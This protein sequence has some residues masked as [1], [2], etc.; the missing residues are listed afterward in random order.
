MSEK[1]NQGEIAT[2][3][4]DNIPIEAVAIV[5]SGDPARTIEQVRQ[6]LRDLAAKTQRPTMQI[7]DE[8]VDTAIKAE[9]AQARVRH[10]EIARFPDDYDEDEIV[11][12]R[13]GM[14]AA[15]EAVAP[16]IRAEGRRE[17]MVE[18]AMVADAAQSSWHAKVRELERE[19]LE[20]ARERYAV[21]AA[22]EI[23]TAIRAMAE[24]GPTD[25]PR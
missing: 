25:E 12:V 24:K 14:R 1:I 23:A 4:G 18:A 13:L 5:W 21:F 6:E 8:M 11:A 19:Y 16:A 10:P 2:L 17:G 15:L 22:A 3:F 20:L 9:A 7:T